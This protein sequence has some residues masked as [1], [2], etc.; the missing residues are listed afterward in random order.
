[1]ICVRMAEELLEKESLTLPDLVR[2]LGD[3]P[4]P[5]KESI[6]EYL[7]ELEERKQK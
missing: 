2:I 1:M 7:Q 6:R 4:F 3:K 5:L